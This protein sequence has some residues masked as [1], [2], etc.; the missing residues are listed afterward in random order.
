M[1]RYSDE[2]KNFLKAYYPTHGI[3]YCAEK[4]DLSLNKVK[5]LANHLGL[6]VDKWW[7][8]EDL[9]FLVANYPS[10]GYKECA[11]HLSRSEGSVISKAGSLKLCKDLTYTNEEIAFIKTHYPIEGVKFCAEVLGRSDDAIKRYASTLGV[12]R[13]PQGHV[14]YCPELDRYFCSIKAASIKLNISDGNICSV[15]KG[16]LKNTN[17]YTFIKIEDYE[18]EKRKS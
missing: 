14:I 6:K 3:R 9:D 18:N 5:D 16:R 4:L 2:T 1:F 11:R 8:K 17:G 13:P 10:L 15:L 12:K 7:S